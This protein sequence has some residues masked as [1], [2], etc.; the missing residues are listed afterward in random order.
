MFSSSFFKRAL[1]RHDWYTTEGFWDVYL[2][3]SLYVY[4]D[5]LFSFFS[6]GI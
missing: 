1:Q 5:L 4:I 6:F 3:I 2:Q